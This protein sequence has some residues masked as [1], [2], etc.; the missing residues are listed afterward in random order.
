[1]A[2]TKSAITMPAHYPNRHEN[3][4]EYHGYRAGM[5]M[6]PC[7][8][9]EQQRMDYM[10]ALFQGARD[11]QLHEHPIVSPD[12][13]PR[14]LDLGCGTGIWCLDMAKI[15]ANTRFRV[16]RDFESP[17]NLGEDSFDLIHLRLGCGSVSNWHEMYSNVFRHLKPQTGR[18]EQVE[19]DIE[20]RCDDGTL[21]E[22]ATINRWYDALRSATQIAGRPIAYNPAT[23]QMLA[24]QGFVDIQQKVIRLPLSYWPGSGGPRREIAFFYPL[25]LTDEAGLEAYSLGPLTRAP[26]SWPVE[27]VMRYC[28]ETRRDI[29]NRNYHVYHEM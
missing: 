7:D 26:V 2:D 14:I 11:D 29:R 6:Y 8:D 18:F 22:D 23:P 27:D 3:G 13:T 4:R 9:A 16:P 10:H 19:I 17:W 5:Y 21:P 12:G 15:H 20:P 24:A 1:M 25:A 28:E